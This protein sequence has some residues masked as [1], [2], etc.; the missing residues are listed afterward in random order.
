MATTLV[1]R[2]ETAVSNFQYYY[3]EPSMPAAI[4]F[5]VLFGLATLLHMFQ[6]LKSRTWFLIPFVIGCIFEAMGYAG[7]VGSAAENPGKHIGG[8]KGILHHTVVRSCLA[9]QD[10]PYARKTRSLLYHS[11]TLL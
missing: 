10:T 11:D 8:Q 9:K 3:Y 1:L 2:E 5:V 7:R 6:M 4:I